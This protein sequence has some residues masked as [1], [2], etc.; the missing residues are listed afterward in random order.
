MAITVNY[1]KDVLLCLWG[2][3]ISKIKIPTLYLGL[4]I[5]PINKDGSGIREPNIGVGGY[6]R[7]TIANTTGADG[8]FSTPNNSKVSNAKE[9]SFAKFTDN[10]SVT[11]TSTA[12]RATHWF[13]TDDLTSTDG[14]KIKWYGELKNSRPLEIDSIVTFGVGELILEIEM[15]AT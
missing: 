10:L 11:G 5:A 2:G 1:S 12:L 9:F 15:P 8:N 3:D 4:S 13:L 14:T 7:V 6:A